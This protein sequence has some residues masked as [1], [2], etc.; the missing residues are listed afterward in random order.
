MNIQPRV[1]DWEIL[2]EAVREELRECAWLLTLMD[3]QQKAILDRDA[4]ILVEVSAEVDSQSREMEQRRGRRLRLMASCN[5]ALGLGRSYS[6]RVLAANVP[7]V[8]RALF[9]ALADEAQSL[10]GRIERRTRQN[11]MLLAR[12]SEFAGQLLDAL[13]PGSQL[14]TYNRRGSV[15]THS[16]L[17]GS[18]VQT[19]V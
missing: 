17:R 1:H 18:V 4:T 6:L 14:R 5:D 15:T 10:V 19:A 7:D 3:R 11:Q 12:A 16:G 13:R 9:L 8:Q 2:A